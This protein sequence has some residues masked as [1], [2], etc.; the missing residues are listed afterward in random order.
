[1]KKNV[2][3]VNV[4]LAHHIADD[5]TY[6]IISDQK[7]GVGTIVKAPLRSKD[8]IGIVTKIL[9]NNPSNNLKIKNIIDIS[10]DHKLNK[11]MIKF[12][13]WVSDYNLIQ[14]GLVLKMI[15]S[16]RKFYFNKITDKKV[17]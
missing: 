1:M 13:N 14:R 11:K 6:K 4:L 16:H 5:L 9:D 12:L 10:G 3:Y 17:D 8:K 2:F 15:L 7:P